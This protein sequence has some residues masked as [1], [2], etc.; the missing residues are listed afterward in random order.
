MGIDTEKFRAPAIRGDVSGV[1]IS[2]VIALTRILNCLDA[3]TNNRAIDPNDLAEA[4]KATAELQ[5]M[6]GDL[7]GW[8]AD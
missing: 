5:K 4:R 2:A 8:E 1:A 3:I 6:F 7:I